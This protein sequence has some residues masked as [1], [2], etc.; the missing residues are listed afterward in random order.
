VTG[1]GTLRGME[2]PAPT[3]EE[4]RAAIDRLVTDQHVS[5]LWF[6]RRGFTPA[7][8]AQRLAL[9]RSIEAR[10]DRDAYIRTRELRDLL[11]RLSSEM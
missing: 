3:L 7:N 1:G 8:D 5:C 4:V 6:V 11:L 9:L 10:A 2:P